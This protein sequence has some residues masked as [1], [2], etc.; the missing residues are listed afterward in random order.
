MEHRF[1]QLSKGQSLSWAA[2]T[3]SPVP[4]TFAS[5]ATCRAMF[6][7]K[8]GQFDERLVL[9]GVGRFKVTIKGKW[10]GRELDSITVLS[11]DKGWSRNSDK[12]TTMNRRAI[13]NET[14]STWLETI[15][16]SLPSLKD[17]RFRFE[18][19]NATKVNGKPA[20]SVRVIE[21]NGVDSFTLFFDDASGFPVKLVASIS[22]DF[23]QILHQ[24][25]TY[26]EYKEFDGI[27]TATNV[28]TRIGEGRFVK[29]SITA[30]R[31]LDRV[32]PREFAEPE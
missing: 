2:R 27:K 26:S 7:G 31:V 13:A 23:D 16:F 18:P 21:P 3:E 20:T 11:G 6:D 22:A 25:V 4:A 19:V 30:F 29:R 9:A 32:D 15:P 1:R 5:T 24:E 8:A 17:P 28:T 14:R 10:D 12:K